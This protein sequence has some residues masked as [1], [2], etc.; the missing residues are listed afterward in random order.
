MTAYYNE[1]D[2]F[3]AQWLRNLIAAGHIAPGDV[4]GPTQQRRSASGRAVGD[5]LGTT[6]ILAQATTC[7]RSSA[8]HRTAHVQA[9]AL[10][11]S[12]APRRRIHTLVG[13]SGSASRSVDSASQGRGDPA[14][15]LDRMPR[16]A[17][18]A[19]ETRARIAHS[20]RAGTHRNIATCWLGQGSVRYDDRTRGIRDHQLMTRWGASSDSGPCTRQ[21]KT[22]SVRAT[23]AFRSHIRYMD[24]L[25]PLS[26][27]LL[28]VLPL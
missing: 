16:P 17:A 22:S 8:G 7:S 26:T 24:G 12:R 15:A 23:P 20:P 5:M 9:C 10:S 11:R 13:P 25:R 21:S 18:V 19:G 27:S 6:P 1:H 14:S 3:A 28:R 4:T 2:A